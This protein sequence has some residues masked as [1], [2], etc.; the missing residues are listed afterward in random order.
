MTV[1]ELIE[2]LKAFDAAMPVVT[3]GFDES[4]YD[5]ISPPEIVKIVKISE[6]R[7][8]SGMYIDAED[9]RYYMKPFSKSFAAVHINF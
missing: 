1:G 3:G 8:H 5:D 9:L 2:A 4:G 7:S 6:E